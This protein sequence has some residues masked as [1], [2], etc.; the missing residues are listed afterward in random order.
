V[1]G[2]KGKKERG[3]RGE[4][5]V[6]PLHSTLSPRSGTMKEGR[7]GQGFFFFGEGGETGKKNYMTLINQ[8]KK[9]MAR[10]EG[11]GAA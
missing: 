6:L 2:K 4:R 10:G 8:G 7:G 1:K 11:E 3:G 9:S 5:G